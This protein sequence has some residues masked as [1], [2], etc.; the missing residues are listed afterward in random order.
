MSMNAVCVEWNA[1][2]GQE[3][4][5]KN[6]QRSAGL[7]CLIFTVGRRSWRKKWSPRGPGPSKQRTCLLRSDPKSRTKMKNVC[8]PQTTANVSLSLT[9]TTYCVCLNFHPS[10][11]RS[12]VTAAIIILL[13]LLW[14]QEKTEAFTA[15]NG[16]ADPFSTTKTADSVSC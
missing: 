10:E 6:D 13:K 11:K 2:K 14:R 3:K 8:P 15:A 9:I 5:S 1:E 16:S 12:F 7:P 4:A